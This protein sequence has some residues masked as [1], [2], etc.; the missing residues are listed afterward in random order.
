[1][2]RLVN[3]SD[4][5]PYTVVPNSLAQDTD[6]SWKARGILVYLL[7]KP[8]DW[9]VRKNHLADEATDGKHSLNSG[10][11][12][13]EDAGYIKA[14]KSR[15]PD[16]TFDGYDYYISAERV[17]N[18][19]AVDDYPTRENQSPDSTGAGKP[20]DGKPP[21][22]ESPP[23]ENPHLQSKEVQNQEQTQ[24]QDHHHTREDE[25]PSPESDT[26]PGSSQPTP[27][28]VEEAVDAAESDPRLNGLAEKHEVGEDRQEVDEEDK[29]GWQEME[30]LI[31]GDIAGDWATGSSS[32]IEKMEVVQARYTDH[33]I[34]EA[35]SATMAAGPKNPWQYFV[36][37]LGE[38]EEKS[39][40]DGPFEVPEHLDATQ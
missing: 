32:W 40:D 6:L 9:K 37:C 10:L 5:F 1:M 20:T 31:A 39:S 22:R 17:G 29:I 21:H 35:H 11:Q 13:L 30:A 36:A 8:D 14:E 18:W 25:N 15:G 23:V 2:I 19:S 4:D 7:S 24:S 34:R 26:D 12:E 27:D 28:V 33:E 16:G 3:V 38:T